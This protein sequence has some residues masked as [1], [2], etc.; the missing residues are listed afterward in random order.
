MLKKLYISI[1]IFYVQ[2]I[3]ILIVIA[4]A[5]PI[6]DVQYNF[7]V[8]SLLEQF[9]SADDVK[10]STKPKIILKR[11]GAEKNPTSTT[12]NLN[13]NFFQ[14]VF[15]YTR[16]VRDIIYDKNVD[17]DYN[18]KKIPINKLIDAVENT[19]IHTSQHI[20]FPRNINLSNTIL[21]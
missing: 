19:L 1:F 14:D 16:P 12:H 11:A 15:Q 7:F 21:I 5:K 6:D 17:G 20:I 8:D 13:D 9:N 2:I 3:S 4:I 10:D 18:N